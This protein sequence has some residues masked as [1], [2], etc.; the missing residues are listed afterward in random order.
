MAIITR[1]CNATFTLVRGL[2]LEGRK[3]IKGWEIKKASDRNK[4]SKQRKLLG[5]R[6]AL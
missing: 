3:K 6:K 4:A 5:F 2:E 1:R